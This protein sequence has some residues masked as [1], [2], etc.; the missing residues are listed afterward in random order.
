YGHADLYAG[1]ECQQHH[2]ISLQ[3]ATLLQVLVEG[4]EQGRRRRVA[5]F[6][7][8]DNHVLRVGAEAP[9]E[10]LRAL[11]DG[12]GRGLMRNQVVDVAQVDAGFADHLGNQRRHVLD[13]HL[14]QLPG[15]GIH[16]G[17][18][19]YGAGEGEAQA[20]VL[21]ERGEADDVDSRSA[22]W[23]PLHDDRGTRVTERQRGELL[24]EQEADLLRRVPAQVGDILA[25]NHHAAVDLTS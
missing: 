8:V 17:A 9:G 19:A 2:P 22:L 3:Q 14:V 20:T 12:P 21:S 25:R 15:L 24:A 18:R 23:S 1:G 4:H 5:V 7:E 11:A 16:L 6:F 13:R 10:F